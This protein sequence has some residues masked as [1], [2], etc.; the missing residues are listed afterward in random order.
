MNDQAHSTNADTNDVTIS[1][2]RERPVA[3]SSNVWDNAKA[4]HSAAESGKAVALVRGDGSR[5]GLCVTPAGE[6]R[7]TVAKPLGKAARKQFKRLRRQLRA[8][9]PVEGASVAKVLKRQAAKLCG[10]NL[11]E[12][13]R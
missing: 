10:L 12:G 13:R 1:V 4:R 11:P 2:P 3:R 6:L 8:L 9:D 5:T 7:R